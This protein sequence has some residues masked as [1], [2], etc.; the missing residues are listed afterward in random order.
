MRLIA[1]KGF[2]NFNELPGSVDMKP[3]RLN[4][5]M[6]LAF[7]VMMPGCSGG[8][9]LQ[10]HPFFSP[11]EHHRSDQ[12]TLYFYR[13]STTIGEAVAPTISVNGKAIDQLAAGG[14]FVMS[15][16]TGRYHIESTSPPI[17]TGMVN[18]RFDLDVENGKVYYIADEVSPVP[19]RDGNTL[20]EVD[21]ASFSRD[22]Y[23]FRYAQVP[24]EQ[25]IVS[26]EWCRQ[27]PAKVE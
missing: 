20:G 10:G 24:A 11:P 25:A 7:L 22:R 13:N 16:P 14:Y 26:L 3:V 5:L 15:L 23:F 8:P 17:V 2:A 18:K 21:D 27:I 4:W 19:F 9:T 12:A 1:A 6:L